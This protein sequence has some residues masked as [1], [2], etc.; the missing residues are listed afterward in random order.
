MNVSETVQSLPVRVRL[1][2]GAVLAAAIAVGGAAF[3]WWLHSPNNAVAV[4]EAAVPA[5]LQ[6]DGSLVLARAE[7]TKAPPAPP[8]ALPAGSKEERRVEVVVQPARGVVTPA[9]GKD[10]LV[11]DHLA[12]AGKIV[13]SCDC[14]PV[15]V[16]LSLV[17][18][19]D[20]TR[21]VIASSPDGKILSGLDIPIEST[22]V[23]APPRWTLSGI[24]LGDCDGL[25][26]GALFQHRRSHLSM[27][28]GVYTDPGM[29]RPGA[30]VSLGVTW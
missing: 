19:P 4:H 16:D 12:D 18:T 24:L 23:V 29:R 25:R 14:P 27:G 10:S 6:A 7:A 15:T 13:D 1:I 17:R 20:K 21:R 3:G 9:T 30:L 8:H 11:A 22:T 26:P 5:Q 2:L 28:A